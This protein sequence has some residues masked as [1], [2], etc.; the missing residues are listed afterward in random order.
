MSSFTT[1]S[2]QLEE[3]EV[4]L[5]IYPD[6]CE[7]LSDVSPRSI[8][9]R[10]VGSSE[11]DQNHVAL[12]M[13]FEMPESYPTTAI[14]NIDIEIEKGISKKQIEEIKNIANQIAN[15]NIGMPAIFTI[16]ESVKEWLQDNNIPGQD[17]SMYADMMRRMQQKDVEIKKKAEKAANSAAANA[18]IAIKI[19]DPEEEERLRKREAGTPVTEETF[20]AWKKRFEEE[21]EKLA[22]LSGQDNN[23]DKTEKL[24]GKQLFVL[25]KA[26]EE[27]IEEGD[28]GIDALDLKLRKTTLHDEDDNGNDDDDDDDDDDYIPSDN[29]GDDVDDDDDDEDYEDENET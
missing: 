11:P 13:T 18:E 4:L 29:E 25:S 26:G 8:K 27:V 23:K 28:Q 15:E 20:N 1:D 7:L 9:I 17:G 19:I 10:L 5:S 24:T 2:E 16:C 3:I 22:I 12:S 6:E 14:P 21:M